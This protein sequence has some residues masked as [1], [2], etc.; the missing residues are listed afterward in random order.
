VVS[1]FSEDCTPLLHLMEGKGKERKG[2]RG[3]ERKRKER[4][5]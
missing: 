1:S 2:R 5:G 4:I 3:V